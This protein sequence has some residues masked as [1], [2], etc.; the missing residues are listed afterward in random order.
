MC[1]PQWSWDTPVGDM[2]G[3]CARAGELDLPAIAFT[4][5]LD[6]TVWR[7]ALA[8]PYVMDNLTALADA[9]GL[10]KPPAFDAAGYLE[11]IEDCRRRFPQ[12]RILSGLELGEPHRHADQITQVLA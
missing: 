9:D 12:L 10:L 11:T 5:H 6:H 7:I 2:E 3:S 4:E 1:T 8:G